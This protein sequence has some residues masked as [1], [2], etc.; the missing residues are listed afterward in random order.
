MKVL[1]VVSLAGIAAAVG[2]V[3]FP[4]I[5]AAGQT[6]IAQGV[7]SIN[8]EAQGAAGDL[9][10]IGLMALGV[11]IGVGGG[12]LLNQQTGGVV[13]GGGLAVGAPAIR[14]WMFQGAAAGGASI[15]AVLRMA[16][17]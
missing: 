2:S 14:E 5:A 4:E 15:D 7:Q 13:V 3:M 1:G 10:D 16:G 17:L 11:G 12:R 8:Q 9:V 6:A